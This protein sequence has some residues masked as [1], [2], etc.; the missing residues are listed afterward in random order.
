VINVEEIFSKLREVLSNLGYEKYVDV[1]SSH[2]SGI[3]Y[4]NIGKAGLEFLK[5]L[6]T[7]KCRVKVF[8]TCNP[9]CMCIED[10]YR[11]NCEICKAQLEILK[12]LKSIGVSTW[13]TCI[14]YEYQNIKPRRFYA[15]SES[16]AVAF[17]N[18]IYDAYV[19]KLPGPL[20]LICALVGKMP[21][22][23]LS[24]PKNRI[25][26]IYVEVR[27]NRELNCVEAGVLGKIIGEKYSKDLDVVYLKPSK[28]LFK[29]I[30]SLKSFLAS[31]STYSNSTLVIIDRLSTNYKYYRD[32]MNIESRLSIDIRDIER[33]IKD[34]SIQL[35]LRDLKKHEIV[36]LGCPHMSKDSVRKICHLD[37]F[38]CEL[39]NNVWIFTSRFCKMFLNGNV[40]FKII[41]DTCLFVSSYIDSIVEKYDVIYTNSVKQYHYLSKRVRNIDV[42]LSVIR[43]IEEVLNTGDRSLPIYVK[44]K[45]A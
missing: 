17:I 30:E 24:N 8:T 4:I 1:E 6:Y 40:C 15:W 42:R 20:A 14:P 7:S 27:N 35:S 22:I 32:S 21:L 29:N 34:I 3:S 19:E 18:S 23:G 45:E 25:P 31:F 38:K 44:R 12:I 43:E 9:M 5:D 37:K 10:L 33:E 2:I 41:Y 16:S 28:T 39:F 13:F 11:E 36:V 26:K